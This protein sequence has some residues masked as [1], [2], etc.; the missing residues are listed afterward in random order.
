MGM[1]K[2]DRAISCQYNADGK[3]I[4][5]T[6]NGATTEYFLN[7][8][9]IL[10]QKTGESTMWFFYDSEGNRIGMIRNGYAFYYMYN[11]Q[12]DVIGLMDARNGR[13][14]AR[15]T[16][17]A[18]GNCTVTNATG[19]TVGTDNPFRYR[20]YYYDTET[21]LYYLNSR[22]YDPEVGRFINADN[23]NLLGANGD[24]A[25]L[26]LFA[27]CGNNPITRADENGHFWNTIIGAVAGALVGGIT[28]AIMGTDIKAGVVSG[29]I[30]GAITGAAVDFAIA[31]G[32]AGIVAF[33]AIT[34][35]GGIGGAASSYVNQRMNGKSHDEIDVGTVIMDGAWGAVGAALTFGVADVGGPQAQMLRQIFKQPVKKI[36]NQ[37]AN[38]F[39]TSFV[40]SASTW[41]NA[42]KMNYLRQ[43]A[44]VK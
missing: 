33:A 9:Q 43:T 35:A 26:N 40:I 23:I 30:N 14:V 37:A 2:S 22:Y 25:S 38:D 28:A 18:W 11:L 17:D 42:T 19:F 12:G 7:G 41:L 20:G 1:T 24:F 31:T 29:A 27:Y 4:S 15:Y 8:S 32:G 5:K 36:L 6:V 10:A 16:Y 39:A 3:R 21:G 13:I 34:I 44:N